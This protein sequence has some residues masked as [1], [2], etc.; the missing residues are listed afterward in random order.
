MRNIRN[1]RRIREEKKYTQ[2]YVGKEIGVSRQQIS[3]IERGEASPRIDII[4]AIAKVLN[5]SLE[6]LIK[7]E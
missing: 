1:L 4:K 6:E 5:V 3:K 7:E 2:T